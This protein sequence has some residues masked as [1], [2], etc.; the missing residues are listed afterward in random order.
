MMVISHAL[1]R[2]L[3]RVMLQL[4][5]LWME[6]KILNGKA[7]R[8]RILMMNLTLGGKSSLDKFARSVQ[9]RCGI[10]LTAVKID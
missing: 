9:S 4:L 6:I 1:Q 7:A 10:E 3:H 2:N 8:A 5:E